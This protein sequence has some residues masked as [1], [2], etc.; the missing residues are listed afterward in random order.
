MNRASQLSLRHCCFVFYLKNWRTSRRNTFFLVTFIMWVLGSDY[1]WIIS[2]KPFL[3]HMKQKGLLAF[4][5]TGIC[6]PFLSDCFRFLGVINSPGLCAVIEAQ[7]RKC[8][9][10]YNSWWW[11]WKLLL[12]DPSFCSPATF[13]YTAPEPILANW[14]LHSQ[15]LKLQLNNARR[16]NC[17]DSI[18]PV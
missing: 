15:T 1:N 6:L 5:Q 17:Y 12:L 11:P 16:K 4:M 8:L 7:Q 9:H 18:P 14:S 10:T 2:K 13:M 3:S